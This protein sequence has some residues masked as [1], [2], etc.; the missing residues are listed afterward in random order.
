M[1]PYKGLH[2]RNQQWM[3]NMIVTMNTI[4][5]FFFVE[6]TMSVGGGTYHTR[7]SQESL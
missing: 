7:L 6:A 1:R 3:I 2:A 5:L 4:V